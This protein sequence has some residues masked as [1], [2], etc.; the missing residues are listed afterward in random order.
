MKHLI[1]ILLPALAFAASPYD[2]TN[3]PSYNPANWAA[4]GPFTQTSGLATTGNEA[5][6]Y[7]NPAPD[8]TSDY[9][10]RTTYRLTNFNPA[11][12]Y[13]GG[14]LTY[15][16]APAL[17]PGQNPVINPLDGFVTG[18]MFAIE[19]W[20]P[21][22]VNGQCNATLVLWQR[23]N[24]ALTSPASAA[25]PCSDGMT[26][27][28]VIRSNLLWVWTDTAKG[29]YLAIA[30]PVVTAGQ[31]GVGGRVIPAGNGIAKVELY[32]CD[33]T[34]PIVPPSPAV[35]PFSN[36]IEM[37]L[38]GL[39]DDPN[40]AGFYL[41][42]MWRID[43]AN[44]GAGWLYQTSLFRSNYVDLT[45][46]PSHSYTYIVRVYDYH[47]NFADRAVTV[48]T[49]AAGT[50]D[51]R[52]IGV[53]STG[54]YWGSLGEQ[55]DM[56]NGNL[57]VTLPIVTAKARTGWSATFALSYNSQNW[58]TDPGGSWNLGRDTGFGYGWRLLAGSIT[59]VYS[60]SSIAFYI[61]TDSTGAEYRLAN[62]AVVN[63][64]ETW[65]STE[66]TYVSYDATRRRLYFN[67]GSFWNMSVESSASEEDAGTLYPSSMQDSNGNQV[68]IGY[69]P[70]AGAPPQTPSSS[71]ITQ[72][73]DIRAA[74]N[75]YPLNRTYF[76]EYDS[77]TVPH[78]VS[79]R[80]GDNAQIAALGYIPAAAA[81]PID[82][83]NFGSAI[84]LSGLLQFPNDSTSVFQYTGTELTRM[85]TP[86]GGYLN[87][88]Y[89]NFTYAG[90]RTFREVDLRGFNSIQPNVTLNHSIA[91][92]D[93]TD[94]GL[95]H[96][97]WTSLWDDQNTS[98]KLWSF[99]APQRAT[100]YAESSLTLN[101]VLVQ[102]DLVWTQPAG[103]N[104]YVS[105]ITSTLEPG[106][107]QK[108]SRTQQ[109]LDAYGN[110]KIFKQYDYAAN[111]S[112]LSETTARTY[113][114]TYI[115]D[116]V[117]GS[118][119]EY[120]KRYIRNRLWET[121]L[122]V[123]GY[124]ALSLVKNE[125]EYSTCVAPP[126]TPPDMTQIQYFDVANYS[127]NQ[128]LYRGN[129]RK[130]T[131][132]GYSACAAYD[133]TGT[134][135][136]STDPTKSTTVQTNAGTQYSLPYQITANNLTSN[137][138][139]NAPLTLQGT[140]G[141][142]GEQTT[143]TYDIGGRVLIDKSSYGAESA[144][145]YSEAGRLNTVK[146][147][148]SGSAPTTGRWVKN[149]FDGFG[150]ALKSETGAGA[151]TNTPISV[152][153]TVYDACAC[154]PIGKMK[155]VSQPHA[156]AQTAV[157]TTYTYDALGRTVT[158]AHPHNTSTAAGTTSGSTTY[159]YVANSTKVIDPA[160]KW[161][162]YETNAF[163]NLTWVEEPNPKPTVW[164][165][166]VYGTQYL[167][168]PTNKLTNATTARDNVAQ[169][170]TWTYDYLTQRLM[171]V[172]TPESGTVSYVYDSYGRLYSK[173]DAKNQQTRYAY[174][175][176][177]RVSQINRYRAG[178]S[179]PDPCQSVSLT[180]DTTQISGVT[181]NPLG[182][183]MEAAW[184][185]FSN[186][187]A[188]PGGAMIEEYDYTKAGDVAYKN[189]TILR[190]QN[191]VAAAGT[192]S[193]YA[194]RDWEGRING[195]YFPGNP[196]FDYG[197]DPLGRPVAMNYSNFNGQSW[198][199]PL[200]M[201]SGMQYNAA[202]QLTNLSYLGYTETRSYNLRQQMTRITS[203]KPSSP[204][205]DM[206]YTFS[207]TNNNGKI[208]KQND[209]INNE[210]VNYTYD[211]LQRMITAST[212]GP[213]WGQA[214]NYDGWGNLS[215]Q[216]VTKGTSPQ[217]SFTIN[218][219]NNR[220]ANY[221]YDANGNVTNDLTRTYSY[222]VENRMESDGMGHSYAYDV[223]NHRVWDGT[224]Y[225]FWAPDGRRIGRYTGTQITNSVAFQPQEIK[226][227]FGGRLIASGSIA[228]SYV[229]FLPVV[230]DRLGSVRVRGSQTMRYF[231][232]GD[233]QVSTANG[234][235][236]FATYLRDA[237]GLDYADQRYHQPGIGRFMTAAVLSWRTRRVGTGMGIRAAIPS[238]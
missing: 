189:L 117:N 221:A 110:L 93:A 128:P 112:A 73:S 235:D 86:Y 196:R 15:L 133:T 67:D 27:R 170:R 202:G 59:P 108:V 111:A 22:L 58:R 134:L 180:W 54:A 79:I 118:A 171:S 172:T 193:W 139:W 25:I 205:M 45:T 223:Q 126:F 11:L 183:L 163:G 36:K 57:N 178:A 222:D 82:G 195:E 44:P 192:L 50:T 194:T 181:S 78:L 63:G 98:N 157:W 190:K 66:G 96:H 167:Y 210:E 162:R 109:T 152:V 1:A 7:R 226:A 116:G 74:T 99:S 62:S 238:I 213:Q 153:D 217:F 220:V 41:T 184:G 113:T 12:Q 228:G 72:I 4:S 24:G 91:H 129:V 191:G 177:S 230:T 16:R 161:K 80:Q 23:K 234:Y 107:N 21:R 56:Q 20:D 19:L 232:Y 185:D 198:Q 52:Q 37:Q 49:P 237:N 32:P 200:P 124:Q 85:I 88:R 3:F 160:G 173:T 9:E 68:L 187:E 92:A 77:N 46:V 219:A 97:S 203:T 144:Y 6:I 28:A 211:D 141:P 5:L 146:T 104:A 165:P 175:G 31:P 142:N 53:R 33:R 84:L 100:T 51:P 102:R 225:T 209:W 143:T 131:N 42:Q 70:G 233:E 65:T 179:Q 158:I 114:S 94:A 120:D 105:Q 159:Q 155:K 150:R 106:T 145:T 2:T 140:T 236:K 151:L 17:A 137:L 227:Y 125:Y 186:P 69:Y 89:R 136:S 182:R 216:T 64:Y 121:I 197:Y 164:N 166:V 123:P 101:K 229:T 14:F 174:D 169:V 55:I 208:T 122:T 207:G 130:T 30:N 26:V 214:F 8:G 10:V 71:R 61:Y 60:S 148:P 18:D 34:A 87:W 40:G 115:I 103:Q 156:P 43:N 206:E 201:V 218:A 48:V 75:N 188:C 231:P 76:F 38:K 90:S 119:S 138:A 135:R 154:S 212:T 95:S 81:S 204:T 147:Y 224:A 127:N 47:G 29:L 83:Q 13:T 168:T 132:P 215:A 39:Q 149:Y 176:S 35:T 199:T